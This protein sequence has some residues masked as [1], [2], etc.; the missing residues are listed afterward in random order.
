MCEEEIFLQ[1][2]FSIKPLKKKKKAH[3]PPPAPE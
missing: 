1:W 3:A 2:H